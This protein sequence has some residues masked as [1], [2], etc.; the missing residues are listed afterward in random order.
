M[1]MMLSVLTAQADPIVIDNPREPI[2]LKTPFIITFA[3]LLEVI[4]IWLILRR[5]QKPRFFILWLIGMHVLTYP[6][7]LGLL[8]LF[9]D[10]HPVFAAGLGEGLVV[11]VEGMLVYLICR[12]VTPS[13]PE[14]VRP[15]IPQC[16]LAS[17]LGNLCSAVAYPI[18]SSIYFLI[19][20][21]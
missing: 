3:I 9:Q 2:S 8:W 19:D 13:N 1:L 21:R 6:P 10:T 7:F 12:L 5:S 20:P 14:L 4:C 15:S 17:F 11:L 16:L 18:L